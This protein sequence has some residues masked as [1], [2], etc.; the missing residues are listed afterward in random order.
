[1]CYPIV[2][3]GP[4]ANRGKHDAFTLVELLVVIA[5]IAVLVGLLL[6]A[7]QSTREA[8]R[9][10]QC[11]NN[12]KQIML[13]MHN[14]HSAFQRFPAGMMF[15]RPF[16]PING[17]STAYAAI[18]PHMEQSQVADLINPDLPWFFQS[19]EA[20]QVSEPAYLCPS[21]TIEQVHRYPFIAAAGVPVGDSFASCSYALSIGYND[22]YAVRS[23]LRPRRPHPANGPYAAMSTT[24]FR[25]L[26][27]GSSQTFGVGEAASG[28]EM[29]TGIGCN[30]LDNPPPAAGE[31]LAVFGWLVGAANPSA[32][33]AGGFRYAGG[34]SSTVEPLNKWPVTDSYYDV[35]AFA[36]GD[37]RP[38]WEGGPHRVTNF[39]SFH[40]GGGHFAFCDGSVNF[41][42]DSIDMT[43]YRA[44]STMAGGEV[45][46]ADFQ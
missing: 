14:Y 5:I 11:S 32:F 16:D 41:I 44:L 39:R 27:D 38:S 20:V 12:S 2:T 34:F 30:K 42:S 33:Y 25:D 7:V 9:R 37:S 19:P 4:A 15:T 13:A 26:R 18:L 40:V 46:S 35:A 22:G 21:D 23:N 31:R 43:I 8:A 10:M 36:A 24:R 6:S 17:T 29:C 28:K 45:E 3:S 1:M